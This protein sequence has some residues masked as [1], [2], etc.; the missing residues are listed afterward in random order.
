[1]ADL[2]TPITKLDAVNF[3]LKE[4]GFTK[5]NSL[6]GALGRDAGAILAHIDEEARSL[7]RKGM[8][9]SRRDVTLTPD[10]DGFLVL[11][12]ASLSVRP[13]SN[14]CILPYARLDWRHEKPVMRQGKVFSVFRQSYV[15]TKSLT[16]GISE[17][18]TFDDLPDEAR[19]YLQVYSAL[20]YNQANV[21]SDTV[22]KNLEPLLNTAWLSLVQA[23]I[24]N[25]NHR[26]I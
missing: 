21:R 17:A 1:M 5:I 10:V 23:E 4:L 3:G 6:D 8:W 24:D 18:I 22:T 13:P 12:P 19:A 26:F 11:P 2:T 15:W 14:E 7:C 20:E 9:F 16:V 25:S